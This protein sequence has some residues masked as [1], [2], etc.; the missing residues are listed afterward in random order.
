MPNKSGVSTPEYYKGS[1]GI[2][3]AYRDYQTRQVMDDKEIKSFKEWKKDIYDKQKK[4][5][6]KWKSSMKK[7]MG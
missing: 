5:S 2:N 6:S 1:G 3:K 4:D 7:A